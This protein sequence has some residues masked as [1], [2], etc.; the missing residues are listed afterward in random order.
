M[1]SAPAEVMDVAEMLLGHPRMMPRRQVSAAAGVSL[2]SARRFWHALGFPRVGDDDSMFTDA[3]LE[4]LTS[5]VRMVRAGYLDEQTAL[6]MTR[7][8][9][10][11]ADRLAAWQTSVVREMVTER[12]AEDGRDESADLPIALEASHLLVALADQ[13]EPL[14]VYA[15][16]RH[17]AAAI[18]QM[19]AESDPALDDT[20]TVRTVGFA[21]MVEFT[22]L[23]RTLSERQLTHLVQHF[24]T[25]ATDVVTA[26]GGRVVKTI[27]DEAVFVTETAGPAAAIALDLVEEMREKENMPQ[28]RV[29]M[30]TGPVTSQLGDVFGTT[31]NRASRLTDVARPSTVLIDDAS[32]EALTAVSGFRMLRLR[33]RT[34]RG[35]GPTRLWVLRRTTQTARRGLWHDIAVVDPDDTSDRPWP[36]SPSA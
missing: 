21:D 24:Y 32:A 7:A 2:L 23:V 4:A 34:L 18:T 3:D 10:R 8:V 12:R 33:T 19:V 11:S 29:G 15:W 1:P 13:L 26:H 35:L 22:P 27:G 30:A 17:L 9:A 28:L 25:L 14:L 31:V 20:A 5:I 6:A 16:R 36:T